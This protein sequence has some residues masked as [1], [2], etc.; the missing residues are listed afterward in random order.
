MNLTEFAQ[1]LKKK[2]G[3]PVAYYEFKP[4]QAPKLPYVIYYQT[5]NDPVFADNFNY[6]DPGLI[7]VELYTDKKDLASEKKLTSFFS[8]FDIPYKSYESKVKD[9]KM[10]EVLYEITI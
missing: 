8:A 9:Q 5:A 2:V 1:A 7:N 6:L 10:F 4:G 3:Y